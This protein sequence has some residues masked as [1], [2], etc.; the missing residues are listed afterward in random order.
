MSG[1]SKLACVRLML[2]SGLVLVVGLSTQCSR[3]SFDRDRNST[4][5][6]HTTPSGTAIDRG[7][8]TVAVGKRTPSPSGKY[9]AELVVVDPRVPANRRML[10][11]RIAPVASELSSFESGSTFAS[12][13]RLRVRWDAHDRLWADSG[14]VGIRFWALHE[15]NWTEF[16]W[17]SDGP[18]VPDADHMAWDAELNQNVFI[19]GIEP[20][21]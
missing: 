5:N 3:R 13:F 9:Q 21:P 18:E 1:P 10:R 20:P 17:Q 8:L 6:Q 14:D 7:D 2:L 15:G 11:V 16:L 12:W 19:L 4:M